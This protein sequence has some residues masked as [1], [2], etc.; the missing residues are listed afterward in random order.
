MADELGKILDKYTVIVDKS[1]VPVGTADKVQAAIAKHAKVDFDVVSNPEFLRDGVAVDDFLKP[2]RVVIGTSSDRARG[3]ME[4]LYRPFVRQGNPIIF[5]DERSAE[6]TKYAANS[7]CC[8][9]IFGY[10]NYLYE[11]NCQ[12]MR[13]IRCG[14][15]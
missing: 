4:K 11:R 6:L 14:C 3:V 7:I 5:M 10:K 8:K 9:L 1:T 13:A 2:E 15:R 12:F